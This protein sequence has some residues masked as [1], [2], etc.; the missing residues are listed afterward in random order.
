MSLGVPENPTDNGKKSQHLD[1]YLPEEMEFLWDPI[2]GIMNRFPDSNQ[3]MCKTK[4]KSF[5]Q[6]G[7][8]T[9]SICRHVFFLMRGIDMTSLPSHHWS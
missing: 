2:N 1:G 3:I 7:K 5:L 4:S 9:K 6:K 8:S